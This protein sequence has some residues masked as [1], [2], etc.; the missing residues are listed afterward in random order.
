MLHWRVMGAESAGET[1]RVNWYMVGLVDWMTVQVKLETLV[2]SL[3]RATALTLL[4]R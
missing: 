2:A 4:L 3:V 1:V